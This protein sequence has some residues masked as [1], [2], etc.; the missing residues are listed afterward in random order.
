MPPEAEGEPFAVR[1]ADLFD[2]LGTLDIRYSDTARALSGRAVV[3]EGFLSRSHGPHSTMSLVDQPGLCPDCSPVPA[4]VIALPGV[5]AP[6]Q[7]GAGAV[8]VAGRLD[9]GLRVADGVASLLRI[10]ES[11][12]VGR[13]G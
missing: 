5:R 1:F 3:I 6:L 7:E 2:H 9:Y 12:I 11:R 13:V 8:R 10:E 4:A